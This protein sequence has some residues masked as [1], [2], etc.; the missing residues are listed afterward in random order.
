MDGAVRVHVKLTHAESNE[1]PW[2][3]Q[4][5]AIVRRED[6][7]Y[8]V[9]D[10]IYLKGKIAGLTYCYRRFYLTDAAGLAG[11]EKATSGERVR[12]PRSGYAYDAILSNSGPTTEQ[13][14]SL[15]SSHRSRHTNR[16][17]S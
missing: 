11:S 4:V 13:T 15:C 8:V 17:H 12:Y 2:T 9:D 7:R 10:V 6:G 14:T 1:R 3:W 16:Q 5:A